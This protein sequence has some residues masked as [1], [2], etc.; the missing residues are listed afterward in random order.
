MWKSVFYK[1]WLKIRWFLLLFVLGEMAVLAYSFLELNHNIV[2]SGAQSVW[3]S[4]IFQG[5]LYF[6]IFR[7]VPLVGGVLVALAQYLPEVVNKRI[8][9]TFH[10]PVNENKALLLM[11]AS[12][13]ISILLSYLLFM[14]P[15]VIASL[16]FLPG[17]I[18]FEGVITILP[19]LLAG[20]SSYFIL[21]FVLLEP[22]WIFRLI[23]FLAGAY[24]ISIHFIPAG[25]ESYQP[26]VLILMLLCGLYSFAILFSGY[27]FRKGECCYGKN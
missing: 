5:Y 10:I 17:Q 11:Q 23:Y 22:A 24:F 2:F 15:F 16:F 7:F 13:T 4:I 21:S 25:M 20:L 14:I 26:I 18:V 27:R 1:E 6:K 8:K 12:G 19:W 9:L 3:N